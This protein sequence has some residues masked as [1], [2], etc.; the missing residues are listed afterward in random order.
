[1]ITSKQSTSNGFTL[2]EL[3]VVI[4]IIG[5]LVALLLPAVQ[6][7]RAAARRTQCQNNMKQVGLALQNYHS[8]RG[9]FPPS[10]TWPVGSDGNPQGVAS[11]SF[12]GH[13][14][15]WV[16]LTLP[17]MEEQTTADAFDLTLPIPDVA[18]EIARSTQLPGMLCPEDQNNQ[19][20]FQGNTAAR[21]N[22]YGPNWGRGNYA[23]NASLGAMTA[24]GHGSFSA[25]GEN[26]PGWKDERLRGVMGANSSLRIAQI[27]DGTSY[28]ILAAEIR[29]GVLPHDVRGTWALGGGPSALWRH[30]YYGDAAGPNSPG[31]E[32]DDTIGC[33][34][35]R[36]GFGGVVALAKEKMGCIER[37][38][39]TQQTARSMHQGGVFAVFADGSVHYISDDVEIRVDGITETPPYTS[40][41]DRLNLSA[42][43]EI[44]GSDA[45]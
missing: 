30:G 45:Y 9:I 40:V 10:S 44:I 22:H 42:D 35:V 27:S 17:Y 25:A 16:I 18:N 19:V 29:A 32:A 24:N 6:S 3:L 28:T 43:G 15:N 20:L 34:D 4:A 39:N 21:T 38:G 37:T 26:S 11:G 7:A 1:M 2:V 12:T 5:I 13:Q 41:W 36:R 33:S 23:A 8:A 31:I 14:A